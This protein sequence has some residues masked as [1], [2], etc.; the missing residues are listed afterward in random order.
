MIEIPEVGYEVWN[1]LVRHK[2]EVMLSILIAI[3]FGV[4]SNYIWDWLKTK[5][6][7]KRGTAE[8]F[9]VCKKTKNL[10]LED[11]RIAEYRDYYY[12]REEDRK[13]REAL[14]QG[15]SAFIIGRPMAGKT[16]AAYE[17]VKHLK[18][19]K[20]V[21]FWEKLLDSEKIP[22]SVKKGKN[23]LVF[24]DLNK[25]VDKV[26]LYEVVKKF[27]EKSKRV[28]VVTTCRSGKEFEEVEEKFSD[29][30][31]DFVRVEC[32][33]VSEKE[34]KEIAKDAGIKFKSFDG[35][36]GSVFLGLDVMRMRFEEEPEECKSLFL[37]LKLL[38]DAGIFLPRKILVEEIYRRK[39]DRD[40]FSAS[41]S[42][43]SALEKIE[44]DSFIFVLKEFQ[45]IRERHESYLDFAGY[46]ASDDDFR[47]LK[48]ILVELKDDEGLFYLGNAFYGREL[49]ESGIKCYDESLELKAD[50]G[51]Y[52]NRGLAYSELK[53]YDRAI[54]NYRKAI[55]LN[56]KYAEAYSNRGLAYSELKQYD[57]AIEDYGKAIKLNPD[58]PEAYN[59]RG[60]AYY[61]L[62]QYERAIENYGKALELNP[63]DAVAYNN[64]GLAY[65]E[66][67]QYER[68]IENYGKA[69]ELNPKYAKAYY[70]R[71]L[72]YYR[73]NQCE[74]AIENYGKALELNPNDA[75]AYN[76]RGNAYD[77]L[78]QHERA[79]EDYGKAIELNL[80]YAEY[81]GNRGI[82]Y[83]EIG[84]YEESAR[85]FKN[86]GILFSSSE[87]V[88]GS[89]NVFSVCFNLR[90]KIESG[91]VIYCG[92]SLFFITLNP[93]VIIKLRRMKI[94]D[95]NMKKIFELSLSK[96]R[97][98]DI[99]EEIR[100][101]EEREEREE[102]KI[103][104]ERLKRF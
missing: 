76:N 10:T 18:G 102:M 53:Q 34:A 82:V 68:A 86:A 95:E 59:N 32:G 89:V 29:V 65:Y 63:D 70:N 52:N 37:V 47:W 55:E 43:E 77:K 92:L 69:L 44:R 13:I 57:R 48:G 103:L 74:R 5:H 71:G 35:T 6:G 73:L 60:L 87:R 79:I 97:N 22:K 58:L 20:V 81:Y 50:A 42:I 9:E 4:F 15:K 101:L 66:L 96:L 30:L 38:H 94:Q 23:V 31:R 61:E 12:E 7:S 16:R 14:N 17:A 78:N 75:E 72:A 99:S 21:K 104:L 98:E 80:N 2:I 1:F 100:V 27:T 62:K 84:R 54:E 90:D 24:D 45:V 49:F 85:D 41:M 64:R 56:P 83:S 93:D 46:L 40:R 36:I 67:K 8:I 11:F 25:F 51:A 88:D 33:D 3:I 28:V 19:F 26:N 39:L 91:D